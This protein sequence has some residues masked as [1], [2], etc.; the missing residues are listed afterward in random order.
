MEG[1]Q[2]TF[3]ESTPLVCSAFV[4]TSGRA[5]AGTVVATALVDVAALDT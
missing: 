3:Q 1:F 5:S 2:T 4:L